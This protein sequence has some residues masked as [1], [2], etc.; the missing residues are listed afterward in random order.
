MPGVR[1]YDPREVQ[2]IIGGA[3]ISAYADGT[4]VEVEPQDDS[5]SRTTGA[6]GEESRARSNNRGG[7]MTLTI[8]QTSPSNDVLTAFWLADQASNAGVFPVM[9]KEAGSGSTL[10]SAQS[11]WIERLPNVVYSKEIEGREWKIALA[12]INWFV[13]GNTQSAGGLV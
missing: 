3:I 6:D 13:G 7:T 5:Y 10:I 8:K 2:I 4:F 12:D 1:T 11:A 9:L